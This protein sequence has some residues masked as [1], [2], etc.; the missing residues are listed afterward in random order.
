MVRGNA[1]TKQGRPESLGSFPEHG[2]VHIAILGA[3][4]EKGSV[5]TPLGQVVA[6]PATGLT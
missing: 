3:I 1:V 4:Q 2:A 5:V 6:V